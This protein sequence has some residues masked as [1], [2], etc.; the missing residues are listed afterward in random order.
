ME[1]FFSQ[2]GKA[3]AQY[4]V[5]QREKRA[6][7]ETFNVFEV[8]GLSSAEVRTHSPFI[9]ELLRPDG[10][11]G[12][13]SVPLSL[14][15]QVLNTYHEI[16]FAFDAKNAR[17][18]VEKNIGA[19]DEGYEDGGRIDIVVESSGKAIIIEN[20]IYA[21]DQ[22]KQLTRYYRYAMRRY[23]EGNYVLLYLTLDAH[24]AGASSSGD[25]TEQTSYLKISYGREIQS[26][27]RM[28]LSSSYDRPIIRETL[29]QYLFLILNLTNNMASNNDEI[30]QMMI[31]NPEVTTRILSVQQEYKQTVIDTR[32][33]E[34][35]E[36]LAAE[37]D[38]IL[39]DGPDFYNGKKHSR[40]MLHK[41]EWRNA[42]IAIIPD[43][44]QSNYW[45]GVVHR[46][47]SEVLNTEQRAFSMLTD[48]TGR[49]FPFGSKYLPGPYRWLYDAH[50]I[51]DI[52]SGK[53]FDVVGALVDDILQC[54]RSIPEFADL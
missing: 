16:P 43:T 27:L 18:Y 15:L 31:K 50:T 51:E 45:I 41:K 1:Q 17:V 29:K 11:H 35:F 40:L 53:F 52:I 33:K 2:L 24:D 39:E 7:G 36:K 20:K 48:G 22:H 14:F 19:I 13:D 47:K 32:L 38:M 30:I 54:T 34:G 9:A 4:S 6:R 21:G 26:W 12:L 10:S 3:V 37:R 46:D 49:G 23:G 8:L 5:R 44:N 42:A 25:G 28:C